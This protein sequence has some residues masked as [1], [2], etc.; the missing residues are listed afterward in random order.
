MLGCDVID[1]MCGRPLLLLFRFSDAAKAFE[2]C[3]RRFKAVFA[4][5]K[6]T[7]QN[8][9]SNLSLGYDS[10]APSLDSLGRRVSGGSSNG[11][12]GYG[13]IP[14]TPP[15]TAF[16]PPLA[17]RSFNNSA[18]F[19]KM[20][21]NGG[22]MVNGGALVGGGL[23]ATGTAGPP[24]HLEFTLNIICSAQINQDQLWRLFDIIPGLD[25]CQIIGESGPNAHRAIVKYNNLESCTYAKDKLHGLEYPLGERLIVKMDASP[26]AGVA[27]SGALIQ[28]TGGSG[29]AASSPSGRPPLVSAELPPMDG[30]WDSSNLCSVALPPPAPLAYSGTACAQ[31]CFLVCVSQVK[32]IKGCVLMCFL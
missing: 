3:D 20:A 32:L 1:T 29:T 9:S 22:G 25:Y 16:P 30:G 14:N 18:V 2:S 6:P 24:P 21:T 26:T 4:E 10:S 31:R 7:R 19:V 11:Q 13:V 17:T 27:P 8:S 23:L 28:T 15:T 12:G 5:P